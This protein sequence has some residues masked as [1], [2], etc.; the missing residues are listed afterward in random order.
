MSRGPSTTATTDTE[1]IPWT[2]AVGPPPR[3][4]A[5]SAASHSEAQSSPMTALWQDRGWAIALTL[6]VLALTLVPP[7]AARLLGPMDRVHVGTYWYHEDFTVYLAAMREAATTP[8]WLIHNHFTTEP[9]G[10]IMMFPLYV[11]IGKVAA[12]TGLP[13]LGVY[14]GFEVGARAILAFTIY[15]FI[16]ALVPAGSGRRF[17]FVLAVFT[18]GLGFWT[19]LLHALTATPGETSGRLINLYV[20]ATTLG[21]FLTAPHITLGLA[22][23]LGG[24]IAF[25]R[26]ARGSWTAL[27]PLAGCVVVLGLV[28]P[29]NAPVLLASF[30]AYLVVRTLL[31]RRIPW[32][33]ARATAVAAAVGGPI[34]LYNYVAF[35][36]T[37][38]WSETFGTQNL[39][40]SAQP[41][42]LLLDYGVVLLLA[43]LG[44][45]AIRG[46]T[47]VEQRV[48]LAFLAVIAVCVYL[49]VPY[50]RRFAFGVQPALAAFAALGWP[51]AQGALA[52]LLQRLGS[53]KLAAQS[54]ARRL[55]GYSLIPLAFTT[56]LAAYF[57]VLSSAVSGAPLA[58]YVVDRDTYALGEWIAA[59]SGPDDVTLGSMD[60]GS[61]L[62]SLVPGHVYVGH[63][64]V[65][66]RAGDKKKEVAALY[67]GQKTAEEARRFLESNR[68]T[69]VVEGPEERK[70][71]GW[72][73]GEQLG[74]E[75]AARE[76]AATAYRTGFGR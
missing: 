44:M 2:A 24:L 7:T 52:R 63:I 40:P 62:A 16:A 71:G 33:A 31:D 58:Y 23:I 1:K 61:A 35:T 18:A 75:V 53:S 59:H 32:G 6:L 12:F 28:H 73:P 57:I 21:T 36:F 49:P 38:V 17:G 74:L 50:Q 8:S 5:A 25:A 11:L 39:L 34:V 51:V 72:D 15:A 45:L 64:G 60:T 42:E 56:V 20:E 41:W 19:A 14:G 22:S 54:V 46:R 3:S 47:T 10:P 65:T 67:G 29:F 70:L 66:V 9:H 37:P 4:Y 13:V 30:G 68:V 69:Y 27:A 48:V 76:G 43:P 55:L 26:A